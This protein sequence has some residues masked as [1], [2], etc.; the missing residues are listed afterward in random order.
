MSTL[1]WRKGRESAQETTDEHPFPTQIIQSHNLPPV[2]GNTVTR[3]VKVP[4]IGYASAYAAGDAF[5]TSFV[6]PALFRAEKPSG[7]ITSVV[8]HDLDDENIQLDVPLF[9]APFTA[10]ADNS[11]F[12]PSDNDNLNCRGVISVTT[13]SNWANNGLGEWNGSKWIN[14]V[15]G[16]IY[17][18]IVAQGAPNIAAGKEPWIEITVVPD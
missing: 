17:T 1:W 12:A 4:G 16:N 10:T 8:I 18:Q 14:T 11:A 3:R 9:I 13:F 15:D 6:F 2:S 5:G 7:T